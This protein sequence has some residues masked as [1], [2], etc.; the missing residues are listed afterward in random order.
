[1][2]ELRR[3]IERHR[4]SHLLHLLLTVVTGGLWLFIWLFVGL[5]NQHERSVLEGR[6]EKL[7]A[8]KPD[9]ES[10][11]F[12]GTALLILVTGLLVVVFLMAMTT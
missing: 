1:M 10:L 7:R 12:L 2:Q 5:V 8:G 11:T 3:E 9:P 4:T 6:I